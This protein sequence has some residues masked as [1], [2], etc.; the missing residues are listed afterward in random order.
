MQI[1]ILILAFATGVLL[2]YAILPFDQVLRPT[3]SLV[4]EK[5][6][7]DRKKKWTDAPRALIKGLAMFNKPLCIGP[8]GA[9]I[10]KDLALA[11][12]DMSPEEFLLIKELI[13]GGLLGAT[14]PFIQ[15]DV[16]LFTSLMGF[17]I[18]YILPEF[19]LKG[20]ISKVKNAIVKQLPDTID[21]LGLC[22]NAGLDFMLALKWVI[23]KTPPSAL[24]DELNLIMQEI[25]VGK[26]RRNALSDLSKKY[27]LPDLT[28]F[29]RTLIQADRMGTSVAEALNILSEDM[30]LARFRRGE[31]V[32]LKA[33]LKMLV[34]LLLFIFPVV[35]ILVGAPIFLDFMQNNPMKNLVGGASQK[36]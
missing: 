10:S 2:A 6:A 23:E 12:V 26:S 30:R 7:T 34:P 4:H 21:L 25:N 29:T 15:A 32:A 28:T 24:A 9:R 16:I 33:P 11:K 8:L 13:I 31:Q 35:A 36:R 5:A 18:G 1:V 3:L 19:W 22:V 20:K 17:A 14:L 27:D